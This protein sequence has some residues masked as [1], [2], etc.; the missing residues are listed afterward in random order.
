MRCLSSTS[1]MSQQINFSSV[2]TWGEKSKNCFSL[3]NYKLSRLVLK[4]DILNQKAEKS[5]LQ[6][7][8]IILFLCAISQGLF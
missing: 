1:R 7:T 8:E 5:Y 2:S 3:R 4:R 6:V